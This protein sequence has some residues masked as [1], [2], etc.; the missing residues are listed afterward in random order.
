MCTRNV[1]EYYTKPRSLLATLS[2]ADAVKPK[3]RDSAIVKAT[4]RT[5][6]N[7]A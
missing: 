3:G 6:I 4:E 5:A 1:I 7:L 2:N